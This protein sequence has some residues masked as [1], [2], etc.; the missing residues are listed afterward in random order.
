MKT[1]IR[2]EEFQECDRNAVFMAKSVKEKHKPNNRERQRQRKKDTE[3]GR[4]GER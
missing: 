1:K 3:R 4:K 2:W